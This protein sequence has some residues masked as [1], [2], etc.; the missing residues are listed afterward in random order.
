MS[1]LAH[2]SNTPL[3]H[4]NPSCATACVLIIGK[5][6]FATGA[7]W[8]DQRADTLDDIE[9]NFSDILRPQPFQNCTPLKRDWQRA[10]LSDRQLGIGRIGQLIFDPIFFF[11]GN[12]R[13]T[14]NAGRMFR[15]EIFSK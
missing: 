14:P 2:C 10:E 7:R 5:V 12:C 1:P 11:A 15:P 3:L 13:S 6:N 4:K 9:T 8:V